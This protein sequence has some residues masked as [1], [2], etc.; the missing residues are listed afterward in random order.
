MWVERARRQGLRNHQVV[1]WVRRKVGPNITVWRQ[2]KDGS[3]ACATPC[4][5]CCRELARFDLKVHCSQGAGEW[6][7][8]KLEEPTAPEVRPTAGQIRTIL[9]PQR[10]NQ[11][12]KA[13]LVSNPHNAYQ[14]DK[15]D[16]F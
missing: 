4:L 10:E 7:I 13:R 6:F 2:H 16:W 14:P 11:Q 9:R 3:L 15:P 8:G 1:T 5:F 12:R